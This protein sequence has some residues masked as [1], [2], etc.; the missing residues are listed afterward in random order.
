MH[1]KRAILGMKLMRK[2]NHG[3]DT[4]TAT[5]QDHMACRLDHLKMIN[6]W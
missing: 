4:N 6:R 3:R 5:C 2:S 1:L